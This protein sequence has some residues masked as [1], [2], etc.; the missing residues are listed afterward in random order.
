METLDNA[1]GAG[2]ESCEHN[3]ILYKARTGN[4]CEDG[5]NPLLLF[6]R[7]V[8][9]AVYLCEPSFV[10]QFACFVSA[11]MLARSSTVEVCL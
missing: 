11:S 4:D 9:L 6:S 7:N 1:P 3:P 8:S 5:D 2:E 10:H